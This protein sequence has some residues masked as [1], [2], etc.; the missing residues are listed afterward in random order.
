[1]AQK[2][3]K[4]MGFYEDRYNSLEQDHKD[5]QKEMITI[6]EDHEE[7]KHRFNY[8]TVIFDK[9]KKKCWTAQKNFDGA[10]KKIKL[11]EKETE[12]LKEKVAELSEKLGEEVSVMDDNDK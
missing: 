6:K 1:M 8:Q 12:Q 9:L 10:T 5:L 3:D 7:Q 2:L 11:F 4:Y